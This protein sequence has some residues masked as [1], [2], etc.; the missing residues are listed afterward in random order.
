MALSSCLRII[1]AGALIGLLVGCAEADT[2]PGDDPASIARAIADGHAYRKHVVQ[3]GEFS[4]G[5]RI[6]G[7][8]FPLASID[9]RADFAAFI[10]DILADPDRDKRLANRRHGYWDE[11]TGTVVI[12]NAR[13]ADCGTAFRPDRG[14]RYYQNLN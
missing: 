11:N 3:S 4:A 13:A 12:Y 8:A 10:A 5:R 7:L 14:V 2:C 9:T 1:A 6:D